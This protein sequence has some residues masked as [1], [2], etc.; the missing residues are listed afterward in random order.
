MN[1]NILLY[2]VIALVILNTIFFIRLEMI[3]RKVDNLEFD[4]WSGFSQKLIE[5]LQKG[6]D[7]VE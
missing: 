1:E 6:R 7:K 3:A 4:V 5:S 2:F